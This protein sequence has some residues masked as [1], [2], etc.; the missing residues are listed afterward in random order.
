MV[1]GNEAVTG[2][3]RVKGTEYVEIRGDPGAVAA[4]VAE[5]NRIL[6]EKR[7]SSYRA[8]PHA[9]PGTGGYHDASAAYGTAYGGAYGAMPPVYGMVPPPPFGMVPPGPAGGAWGHDPFAGARAAAA[10]AVHEVPPPPV[11]PPAP[12]PPV[13]GGDAGYVPSADEVGAPPPPPPAPPA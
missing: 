9:H 1:K 2:G 4:A 6:E 10:A 3:E 8:P 11:P 7:S 12:P 13:A 5:V